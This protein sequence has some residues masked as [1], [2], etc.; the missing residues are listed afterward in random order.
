MIMKVYSLKYIYK[1]V[2]NQWK[3]SSK[4]VNKVLVYFINDVNL[5]QAKY[6]HHLVS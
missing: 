3:T 2:M 5:Q 1:V 4:T 6:G